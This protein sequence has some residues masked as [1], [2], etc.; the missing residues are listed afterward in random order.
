[1]SLSVARSVTIV[2][3]AVLFFLVSLEALELNFGFSLHGLIA[4]PFD[5]TRQQSENQEYH[6]RSV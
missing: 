1:V 3:L 2:L 4:F 6:V 5:R